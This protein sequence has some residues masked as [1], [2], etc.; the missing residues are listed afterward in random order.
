MNTPVKS[1]TAA[2]KN[3]AGSHG[4]DQGAALDDMASHNLAGFL[5]T[6]FEIDQRLQA[7]SH[8]LKEHPHENQ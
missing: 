8:Q 2:L 6:L 3:H 1:I 4:A 7:E 5:G